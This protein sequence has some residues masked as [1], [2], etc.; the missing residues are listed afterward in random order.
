M[1]GCCSPVMQSCERQR[2]LLLRN[3]RLIVSK[4]EWDF[5]TDLQH[6]HTYAA[7]P[8]IRSHGS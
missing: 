6:Y 4:A 2:C 1:M 7:A 3:E 8:Q 5:V